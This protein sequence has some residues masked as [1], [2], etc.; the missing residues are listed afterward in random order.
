MLRDETDEITG[1]TRAPAEACLR[2]AGLCHGC[3]RGWLVTGATA[4]ATTAASTRKP[5][6]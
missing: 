1:T 6:G 4:A 2:H 5:V 3:R